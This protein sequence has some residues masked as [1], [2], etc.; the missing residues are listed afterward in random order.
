MTTGA[1]TGWTE[2]FMGGSR[3]AE[4]ALFADAFPSVEAIQEFVATKQGA[5]IRR[6]FHNRGAAFTVEFEVS[7][8]LPG[9]LRVGFLSPGATY[10]GFGRF[11]RSQS[12]H[13]RDNELDQRGFAFRLDTRAV[14]G[15]PV[16]EHADELRARPRDVPS[17]GAD[18]RREFPSGRSPEA[19]ARRR[20]R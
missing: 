1:G 3:E 17:G 11:S 2:A 16:L 20:D 19:D 9:E 4:R 14:P 15:F 5:P 8:D 6:A 18:L 7:P 10:R 13:G 12:F